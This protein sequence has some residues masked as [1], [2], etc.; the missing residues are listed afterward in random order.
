MINTEADK[1]HIA[2]ALSALVVLGLIDIGQF[3]LLLSDIEDLSIA[4][5]SVS[6]TFMDLVYRKM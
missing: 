5:S 2:K 1:Q 4:A 6:A 3:V